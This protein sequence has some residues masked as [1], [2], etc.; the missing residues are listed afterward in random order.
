MTTPDPISRPS[1]TFVV[2][3]SRRPPCAANDTAAR[4]PAMPTLTSASAPGRGTANGRYPTSGAA[5]W[6]D[7]VT[8]GRGRGGQCGEREHHGDDEQRRGHVRRARAGP[9]RD[10]RRLDER[11]ADRLALLVRELERGA[12][13]LGG[14]GD[15][16]L[17]GGAGRLERVG[18]RGALEATELATSVTAAAA[19]AALAAAGAAEGRAADDVAA[20]GVLVDVGRD[21]GERVAQVLL[22][23]VALQDAVVGA[24]AHDLAAARERG[25]RGG[26]GEEDEKG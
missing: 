11:A 6:E 14:R 25:R 19:R 12:A 24:V 7:T 26:E 5:A 8:E 21:R 18:S 17:L 1:S 13:L 15:R 3:P 20:V 16:R 23:V 10:L 2:R 4:T 9:A 22:R